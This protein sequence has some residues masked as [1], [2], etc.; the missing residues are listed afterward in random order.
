MNRGFKY[1]VVT[2]STVLVGF[3]LIGVV[4]G[5]SAPAGSNEPYRHLNVF[6]EVFAKIKAEYVEEPDM[7]NVTLGAINGLLVSMDPFSSYLNKE[8]YE[9]FQKARQTPK[10]NVGLILSRKYGFEMGVVHAIEGSP[11]QQMGL[12]TGDIIEAINGISTRDMPLAFAEVLLSGEP[13][14]TL[15]LTVLRLRRPEP[16][17]VK[18]TRAM[19]TP[20]GAAAKMVDTATGHVQVRTLTAGSAAQVAQKIRELEKHGA[21]RL[22]LDL[23]NCAVSE[24]EEGILLADLFLDS[25]KIATLE[26]QRVA[27]KIREL[28]KHGARR[29]VL[30]LRNCAVSEPEEGI[31]LADLFLDS[32]KI[33]TLEGQRVAKET[34]EA[35]S[36]KTVWKGPVVVLTNRGTAGAAEIAATALLDNKRAEVVGERSYGDAALRKEIATQDGGAVLL[37]VAKYYSPAGKAIQDVSVTPTHAVVDSTANDA[38]GPDDDL[39]AAPLPGT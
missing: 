28:E 10:A 37:A 19:V 17:T 21:R 18:L 4:L 13:G 8:Q 39:D 38:A 35:S 15:E 31:L 12:T 5:Q 33:A 34:F 1:G 25:G 2:L 3:L 23:R 22:V 32:G 9:A 7:K 11:A 14:S 26:G 36:G 29:L 30:D 6:T 27:K 20:P 16:T 24:P